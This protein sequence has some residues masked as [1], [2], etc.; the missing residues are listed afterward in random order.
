MR[1]HKVMSV[2]LSPVLEDGSRKTLTH[3]EI[4]SCKDEGTARL[5]R[6]LL[7]EYSAYREWDNRN[8]CSPNEHMYFITIED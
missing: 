6:Y 3:N 5:I 8:S 4:C 7:L 1:K 2:E